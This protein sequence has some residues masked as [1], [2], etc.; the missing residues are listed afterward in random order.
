MAKVLLA[1]GD[2]T[3]GA[4]L[5]LLK[6]GYAKHQVEDLK[7]YV[8]SKTG[9]WVLDEKPEELSEVLLNFLRK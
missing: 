2:Q 7:T 5:S 1:G 8:F 9:H 4:L 6:E 3:V